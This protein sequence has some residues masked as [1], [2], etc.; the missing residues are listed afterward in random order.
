MNKDHGS[1]GWKNSL[2][3]N[4]KTDYESRNTW[5][6][7]NTHVYPVSVCFFKN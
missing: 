6:V 2:T 7:D 3:P 1:K 5:T 4:R